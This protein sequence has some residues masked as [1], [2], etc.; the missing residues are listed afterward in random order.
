MLTIKKKNPGKTEGLTHGN[1]QLGSPERNFEKAY[2]FEYE[3]PS[4]VLLL[5]LTQPPEVLALKHKSRIQ[6]Q[7]SDPVSG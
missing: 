3:A 1:I 4:K 5:S 6:G 7:W 2:V